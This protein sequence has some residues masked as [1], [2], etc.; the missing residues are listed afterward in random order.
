[1]TN[2]VPPFSHSRLGRLNG[3]ATVGLVFRCLQ[4]VPFSHN[5]FPIAFFRDGPS[6]LKNGIAASC[7]SGRSRGATPVY[8]TAGNGLKADRQLSIPAIELTDRKAPMD[9]R[10][11]IAVASE[12]RS[13]AAG[14]PRRL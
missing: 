10:R 13:S 8:R 14:A 7:R 5:L 9:A 12:R 1:M 2:K 6:D 3:T 4:A 11:T